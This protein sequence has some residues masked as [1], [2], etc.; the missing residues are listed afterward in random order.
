[1]TKR[2]RKPIILLCVVLLGLFSVVGCASSSKSTS[3]EKVAADRVV[4]DMNGDQITVAANAQTIM[5]VNSVA[6]QIV[7]MLGGDAAACTVGQ[8]FIYTDGSLNKQM[9]PGLNA[10]PTFT[11]D[12]VN[13]ESVMNINPGLLIIDNKDTVTTLRN[14]G[15]PV[16]YV[17]VTSPETL[18]QAVQIIGDALGGNAA[19]KAD[20]YC[21]YYQDTI[22]SITARS[23]SL[24][25]AQKPNVL[26]L[27]S[28][29]QTTGAGSMP[30]FWISAVGGK[31]VG[32]TLGLNGSGASI[33]L[34]AILNANPD[35]II[36]EKSDV[37]KTITTD[38][39]Y[40]QLS[41]VKNGN[42]YLAPFGTAVWSMGTAEAVLQLSWAGTVINPSLYADVNVD[43]VTKDFFNKF[44]GY[45][46]STTDLNTIFHR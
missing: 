40:S 10:V 5:T 32:T 41:A 33:T 46:L 18:M 7:L 38:K 14:A 36:C 20:E 29:T 16:A 24:S 28:A 42:V 22:N 25:S 8:G 45:N 30:D 43:N 26:Y 13:V 44:Y 35:I 1:M 4:T 21:A 34:E 6:T 19:V 15:L 11:R 31:N 9:F 3:A 39:A 12:D 27:R 37:Y 2:V 23:A 17:S